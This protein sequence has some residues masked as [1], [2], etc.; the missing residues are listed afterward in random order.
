M[1]DWGGG[2]IVGL[3][4]FSVQKQDCC[5]ASH[6]GFPTVSGHPHPKFCGSNSSWFPFPTR[7]FPGLVPT[8]SSPSPGQPKCGAQIPAFPGFPQSPC[9][10]CLPSLGSSEARSVWARPRKTNPPGTRTSGRSPCLTSCDVIP[11]PSPAPPRPANLWFSL[12]CGPFPPCPSCPTKRWR[13]GEGR[14][15]AGTRGTRPGS[16]KPPAPARP[17]AGQLRAGKG[18]S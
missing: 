12:P 5:L 9:A 18:S 4:H 17:W 13:G 14:G 16:S 2:H 3:S 8:L 7:K 15:E 6:F 10:T 11:L 1:G